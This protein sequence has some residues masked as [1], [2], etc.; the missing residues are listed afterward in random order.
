MLYFCRTYFTSM[1]SRVVAEA[2]TRNLKSYRFGQ[3]ESGPEHT[4]LKNRCHTVFLLKKRS[5]TGPSCACSPMFILRYWNMLPKLFSGFL[6]TFF[7][8]FIEEVFCSRTG[9]CWRSGRRGFCLLFLQRG[10]SRIHELW[11]GESQKILKYS[12]LCF[13]FIRYINKKVSVAKPEWIWW[14]HVGGGGG[15]PRGGVV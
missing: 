1:K 7:N 11:Q 2:G 15:G 10:G 5:Q 8:V 14:D 4:N 9:L 12:C 3:S 6:L 13:F